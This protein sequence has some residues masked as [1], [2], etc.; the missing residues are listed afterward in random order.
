MILVDTN[1]ILDIFEADPDWGA[2]SA[3]TLDLHEASGLVI[4]PMIYAELGPSSRSQE[5]LDAKL[6][7]MDFKY[8]EIPQAA[9]FR[10]SQAFLEYRQSKG[11]RDSLLPDFLIGAHAEISA[12]SIVTRDPRRYR[13]Y[14]P[15]VPLITPSV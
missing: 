2:W 4:N 11:T 7:P 1:I 15:S 5:E 13:R 8:L 14:F 10:A 12:F 3:A 6:S 9:L